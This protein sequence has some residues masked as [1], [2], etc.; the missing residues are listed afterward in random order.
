M[1]A[2]LISKDELL[3]HITR[4]RRLL[5]E[6]KLNANKIEMRIQQIQNL[7]N[8]QQEDYRSTVVAQF[9]ALQA[10]ERQLISDKETWLVSIEAEKK[11]AEEEI[12]QKKEQAAMMELAL[13]KQRLE[14]E[15]GEQELKQF[16]RRQKQIL[17]KKEEEIQ[18]KLDE[19]KGER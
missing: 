11:A 4:E 17:T 5:A 9:E 3:E 7:A 14:F 10:K 19:V 15:D 2:L 18:E 8:M 16:R 1:E 12:L 6:D 13:Q